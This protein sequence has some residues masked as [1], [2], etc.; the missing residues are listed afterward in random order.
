[1]FSIIVHGG[2]G[3]WDNPEESRKKIEELSE[4][5]EAG[6]R[7]LANGEGA[8]EAVIAAVSYMEDSELFNAGRG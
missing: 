4:A 3:H 8:L 1:M 2:A 6:R 7:K 5:V